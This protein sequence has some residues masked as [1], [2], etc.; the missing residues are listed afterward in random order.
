M[1]VTSADDR[2]DTPVR[3]GITGDQDVELHARVRDGAGHVWSSTTPLD[4]AHP[5]RFLEAMRSPDAR[6]FALPD[7]L[8]IDVE[9]LRGDEHVA[10]TTIER[11]A[12]A[13]GVRVRQLTVAHD[14]RAGTYFAPPGRH[15]AV[16]L[17]GGSEGGDDM[18]DLA[19]LLAGH[20]LTVLTLAYFNAPGR[21]AHL[22]HI[23]LEYFRDAARWLRGQPTVDPRRVAIAGD[24]RGGEAA[25]LIAETYPRLFSRV[26]AF[27]PSPYVYGSPD[28]GSHPA[29]TRRGRP[30]PVGERIPVE[31]IPVPVLTI[32]AGADSVWSSE[33]NVQDIA[34]RRGARLG[35]VRL[36]Y[37]DAGHSAGAPV[38]FVPQPWE[39]GLGGTA[40][41]D[42]DA[43]ADAFP[44]LVRFLMQHSG[45]R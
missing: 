39:T 42:A 1:T 6:V 33:P 35:D 28:A 8:K 12:L 26:A 23:P 11:Q 30:V 37:P 34:D 31:R 45:D 10:G 29:W 21:P 16:L 9:V 18:R 20:G 22:D 4:R 2:L 13:T 15:P 36:D 27:V 19:S 43:R 3:I 14:G 32:G 5:M 44:R 25:L 40:R 7:T 41:A 38:P 17:F 24:S